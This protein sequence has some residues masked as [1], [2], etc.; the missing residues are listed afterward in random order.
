MKTAINGN[1]KST[2][3]QTTPNKRPQNKNIL[4]SRE[5]EEQL[6]KAG[7]TTHN[8]KEKHSGPKHKSRK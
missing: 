6:D 3:L 1:Q 4:D 8:T 7:N 5:G 2:H